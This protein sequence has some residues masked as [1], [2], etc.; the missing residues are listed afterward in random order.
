MTEL[1]GL[2]LLV[3]LACTYHV[4]Y[5]YFLDKWKP[6]SDDRKSIFK[7]IK[8]ERF[9]SLTAFIIVATAWWFHNVYHHT[10]SSEAIAKQTIEKLISK[11]EVGDKSY[12]TDEL[13]W[14]S[15]S[16]AP[17]EATDEPDTNY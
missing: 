4:L 15:K 13:D 5:K 17:W 16:I 12:V 8:A 3:T 1:Y 11:W 10:Y 14:L 2:F 9:A 6:V 7:L